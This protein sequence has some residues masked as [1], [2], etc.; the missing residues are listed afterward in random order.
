M[1]DMFKGI[2]KA[3][4]ELKPTKGIKWR[5]KYTYMFSVN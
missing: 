2:R 4:M 5:A 1:K 3:A